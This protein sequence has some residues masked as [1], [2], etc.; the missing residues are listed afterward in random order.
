MSPFAN[1]K[2]ALM[3]TMAT[4]T[5]DRKPHTIVRICC[6]KLCSWFEACQR[7][8]LSSL[9]GWRRHLVLI[10]ALGCKAF[11]AQPQCNDA[12]AHEVQG[13]SPER[14]RARH[15][16]GQ[17]SLALLH[18]SEWGHAMTCCPE[19]LHDR[20]VAVLRS[21]RQPQLPSWMDRVRH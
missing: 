18:R 17:R 12:V 19:N 7:L 16:Y 3:S 21:L 10:V 8:P 11:F 5:N 13:I 2:K 15:L 20:I 14:R 1:K 6:P 4:S 9:V